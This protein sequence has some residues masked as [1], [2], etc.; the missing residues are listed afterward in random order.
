[1]KY[2]KWVVFGLFGG[3]INL[4]IIIFWISVNSLSNDVIGG[5][6]ASWDLQFWSHIAA[7]A[8]MF[9]PGVL[10]WIVGGIIKTHRNYDYPLPGLI[11]ILILTIILWAGEIFVLRIVIQMFGIFLL[12]GF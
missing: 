1:M 3:L 5:V 9:L 12:F 6:R 8:T 10:F 4:G 2:K 11:A 7:L